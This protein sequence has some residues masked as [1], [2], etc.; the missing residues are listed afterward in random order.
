[1][2]VMK[3]P[4][5]EGQQSRFWWPTGQPE[6]AEVMCASSSSSRPPAA[7]NSNL[8]AS[9]ARDKVVDDAYEDSGDV[10][11]TTGSGSEGDSSSTGAD[12]SAA[13]MSSSSGVARACGKTGIQVAIIGA[14]LALILVAFQLCL[15]YQR[16]REHSAAAL[17]PAVHSPT[18][19]VQAHT[20]VVRSV[21]SNCTDTPGWTNGW[22][23]CAVEPGG[24]DPEACKPNG[25]SC[26]A[27]AEKGWCRNGTAVADKLGAKFHHPEINCCA[28]GG[29]AADQAPA[30]AV[31]KA[32]PTCPQ[33]GDLCC[34]TQFGVWLE[35]CPQ[36][37]SVT[38]SAPSSSAAVLATVA[39][40]TPVAGIPSAACR[41]HPSCP[42][43]DKDCCPQSDGLWHVCCSPPMGAVSAPP[44]ATASARR[45]TR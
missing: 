36:R 32:N 23:G 35:C 3:S 26:K 8:S 13:L 40:V 15:L 4:G 43:S 39:S 17:D 2:T 6:Q 19:I 16:W 31:C 9:I 20:V 34:P 37:P 38:T 29:G 1:M 30:T 42:A 10:S 25:W 18:T 28:C 5:V 21:A 33:T 45:L 44:N 14:A 7:V 24:H 41:A 11:E 12:A 22:A 27:Y